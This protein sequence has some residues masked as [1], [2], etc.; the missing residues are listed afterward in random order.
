VND[1]LPRLPSASPSKGFENQLACCWYT[2]YV[3]DAGNTLLLTTDPAS[4][5]LYLGDEEITEDTGTS[6]VTGTRYY[7]LGGTTVAARTGASTLAYLAGDQ[8]DTSSVA[9]PDRAW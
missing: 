2:S 6:A 7:S 1:R 9:G 5:T 8:Q 3:Y 4:Q